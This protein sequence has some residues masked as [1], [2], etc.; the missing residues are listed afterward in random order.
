M[1]EVRIY[2]YIIG[3]QESGRKNSA[4]PRRQDSSTQF[5]PSRTKDHSIAFKSIP[6]FN[7][8]PSKQAHGMTDQNSRQPPP[9]TTNQQLAFLNPSQIT[10]VQKKE[11]GGK[12]QTNASCSNILKGLQGQPI[13]PVH[14]RNEMG[15]ST[16]IK[17][18]NINVYNNITK[19]YNNAPQN[20]KRNE[21]THE[22]KK[23]EGFFA[24]LKRNIFGI[25]NAPSTPSRQEL[26]K[27]DTNQPIKGFNSANNYNSKRMGANQSYQQQQ[28]EVIHPLNQTAQIIQKNQ[29][30]TTVKIPNLKQ[31]TSEREETLTSRNKKLPVLSEKNKQVSRNEG[32]SEDQSKSLKNS[33]GGLSPHK[34]VGIKRRGMMTTPESSRYSDADCLEALSESFNEQTPITQRCFLHLSGKDSNVSFKLRIIKQTPILESTAKVTNQTTHTLI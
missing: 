3:L 22:P 11:F 20:G 19:N 8:S 16:H 7:L 32:L 2:D 9:F 6:K 10:N 25:T 21:P 23:S 26:K 12:I 29:I 17:N 13:K 5:I 14:I 30:S 24:S 1:E 4:S 27:I 15:S 18:L 33:S 28:R 31:A 34:N